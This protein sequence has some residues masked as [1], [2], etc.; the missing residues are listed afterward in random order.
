MF[1]EADEKELHAQFQ[2]IKDNYFE[3]FKEKNASV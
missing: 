3:T 2:K 1:Y